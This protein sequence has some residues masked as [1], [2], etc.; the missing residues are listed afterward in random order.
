MSDNEK[1]STP[2]PAATILIAR[3]GAAGPEVFMVKRHHQIDFVAGAL[4]FPGGKVYKGD[5]DTAL[6]A[7]HGGAADWSAEMRALVGRRDPRSVRRVGHPLR[8]RGRTGRLRLRRTV[9]ALEH[10]RSEPGK[11]RDLAV[12]DVATEEL[13][14]A[15]RSARPFRALD[16][17]G[18][19][20]RRFD[21]HFSSRL[22]RMVISA[23]T[24][25]ANPSTRSGYAPTM[26]S[27]IAR[28]GT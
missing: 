8:A 22:A 17:A 7:F 5:L 1:N 4:V 18:N 15:R 24:T 20:P 6:T 25:A 12:G 28:N 21:T 2:L 19:M 3:E 10:Y 11:A 16:H 13:R 9:E 23:A 14:L 26:R 27:P